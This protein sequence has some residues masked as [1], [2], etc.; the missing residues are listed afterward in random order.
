MVYTFA[1]QPAGYDCKR[2]EIVLLTNEMGLVTDGKIY[3]E[4]Q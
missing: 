2:M 4:R 3:I 1:W